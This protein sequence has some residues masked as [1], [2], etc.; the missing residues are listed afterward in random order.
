MKINQFSKFDLSLT[1]FNW[2]VLLSKSG[3][4]F[5]EKMLYEKKRDDE[6]LIYRVGEVINIDICYLWMLRE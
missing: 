5:K 1:E 2:L 6:E 4:K 3:K